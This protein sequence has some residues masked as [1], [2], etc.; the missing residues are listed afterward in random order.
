MYFK[1]TIIAGAT[2]E[3]TKSY[4]KRV[5]AKARGKKRKPMTSAPVPVIIC[6]GDRN[7]D[8]ALSPLN[9]SVRPFWQGKIHP[10]LS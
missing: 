1:T 2:I 8:K 6:K 4:T 5:G 10:A 3:V 9:L 7:S